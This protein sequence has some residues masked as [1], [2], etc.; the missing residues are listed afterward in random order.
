MLMSLFLGGE[1]EQ[2]WAK[3]GGFLSF[4]VFLWRQKQNLVSHI[5]C[6]YTV[7]LYL[8]ASQDKATW[9]LT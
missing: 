1:F 4:H 5:A 6:F 9:I 7:S 3:G 8:D 2:Y